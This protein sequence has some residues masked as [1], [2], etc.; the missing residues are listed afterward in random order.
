MIEREDKPDLPERKRNKPGDSVTPIADIM[1][2]VVAKI[3]K[4]AKKKG[5]LHSDTVSDRVPPHRPDL[6]E[7]EYKS[8]S[9]E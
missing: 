1:K 7:E 4:I 5:A 6:T 9:D 8:N 2:R 3:E